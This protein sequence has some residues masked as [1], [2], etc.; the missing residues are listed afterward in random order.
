[1]P[2]DGHAVLGEDHRPV[3]REEFEL[4]PDEEEGGAGEGGCKADADSPWLHLWILPELEVEVGRVA[5]GRASRGSPVS[6]LAQSP[7]HPGLGGARCIQHE[8]GRGLG[9]DARFPVVVGCGLDVDASTRSPGARVFDLGIGIEDTAP[10]IDGEAELPGGAVRLGIR[11]APAALPA[12]GL[13]PPYD[14]ALQ[15]VLEPDAP[16]S[17]A[18]PEQAP[19]FV[20]AGPIDGRIMGDPAAWD[21]RGPEP[22]PGFRPSLAARSRTAAAPLRVTVRS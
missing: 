9:P 4:P 3:P 10:G 12:R 16:N 14:A 21:A 5:P 22:L 19:P 2:D 18:P 11:E 8:P 13:A 15:F 1:M 17:G 20:S 7:K 6:A